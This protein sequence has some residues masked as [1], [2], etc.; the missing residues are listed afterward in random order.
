MK[1][2]PVIQVQKLFLVT[3]TLKVA[4]SFLGWL[5][6]S[7]W[8]L[9]FTVPLLIMVTYIG[10]G[11]RRRDSDVTD[12]KFADTCYY[13]GFIF[14]ITS[15]IFSLFDLPHI[16]TK[17]QDIAVRFG[18][19]MVSTVLGLG[20]RVYL[21]SFR[22]DIGDAIKEAEDAVL[23]A[24]RKFT[25]QLTIALERLRDFESQVDAAAKSSVE[26]VNMQVE[27]L[28][29]N[30]ADKLTGFFSDLTSR[31]QEAF[32]QALSEVKTASQRLSDSVD[33]YSNGM[34]SNLGSIESKVGAFTEAITDRLKTT[35]FPDDYFAKHL[36]SPLGQLKE[37]AD[38]LALG[39]KTA[40]EEVSESTVVL[41]GALTKLRDKANATEGSLDTVLRLTNQQQAVL[42]SAQG[43]L[44]V[45]GK[46]TTNLTNFDSALSKN[47]A[48]ITASNVVTSELSNKVSSILEEGATARRSL[49]DSLSAVI[50]KLDSNATATTSV[51]SK[52]D[53]NATATLEAAATFGE[54]LDA[55][56]LAAKEAAATISATLEASA[57]A[58]SSVTSGLGVNAAASELIASKLDGVATADVQAAMALGV[59]GQQASTAIGR[60]DQA[61]EQLNVMVHKFT[62]IDA[63][64][65]VQSADFK[66]LAQQI[67]DIKVVVEMPSSILPHAF[68]QAPAP[69][70][71][72]AFMHADGTMT[73]LLDSEGDFDRTGSSTSASSLSVPLPASSV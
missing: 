42:D 15:I 62:A 40:T 2:I 32:T 50:G 69:I 9:G 70:N 13:L 19:A 43:Q 73:Q 11:L 24:T 6:Q 29:K 48:S 25:E 60:A 71:A 65:R 59:L 72:G 46:L 34:R 44:T 58:V 52:L 63:S 67:K 35:T 16:G 53:A 21:V 33:G 14:T 7:P 45:L 38:F 4:S 54:K 64:L 37:C 66:Q 18:A 56:S 57:T 20:V 28:S 27:N 49:E 31:N 51:A 30:H 26:R 47:I 61:V 39:V 55:N 8:I 1:S 68:S 23:D 36:Q 3:L 5:V 41:S 10:L 12:E 22:Q 17:I